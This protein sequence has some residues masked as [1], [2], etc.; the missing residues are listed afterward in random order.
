MNLQHIPSQI[1]RQITPYFIIKDLKNLLEI[2]RYVCVTTVNN[3]T[4]IRDYGSSYRKYV[5]IFPHVDIDIGFFA[6]W[7]RMFPNVEALV[8]N[9]RIYK[10]SKILEDFFS[11]IPNVSY[12]YSNFRIDDSEVDENYLADNYPADN[13]LADNSKIQTLHTLHDIKIFPESLTSLFLPSLDIPSLKLLPKNLLFL[14]ILILS[15]VHSSNLED[16]PANLIRLRIYSYQG[17]FSARMLPRG[18][19]YLSMPSIVVQEA[20]ISL[21]PP[22]LR[23]C[24]LLYMNRPTV[25]MFKLWS[26]TCPYLLNLNISDIFSYLGKEQVFENGKS[27]IP[28]SLQKMTIKLSQEN[29]YM[30]EALPRTLKSLSVNVLTKSMLKILPPYLESLSI[31]NGSIEEDMVGDLPDGLTKLSTNVNITTTNCWYQNLPSNITKLRM[32]LLF[33]GDYKLTAT[34]I[35]NLPRTLRSLALI[36]SQSV[37]NTFRVHQEKSERGRRGRFR[38]ENLRFLPSTLKVFGTNLDNINVNDL[39]RDLQIFDYTGNVDGNIGEH[40]P[41]ILSINNDGIRV[42]C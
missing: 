25:D 38:A 33:R 3:V 27:V 4:I 1:W 17:E 26:S 11:R 10:S 31:T 7:T 14:D 29:T 19:T 28:S 24:N 2:N 15:S 18:L 23:Y 9:A 12:L 42:Y 6:D 20:D 30:I 13:Y 5:Y 36:L 32:G 41:G 16:L 35:Y 8:L 39:P 21:L 34:M 37:L 22:S 40:C